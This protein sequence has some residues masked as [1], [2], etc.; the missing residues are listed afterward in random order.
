M[1]GA[2]LYPF[3]LPVTLPICKSQYDPCQIGSL[4][5]C[6]G[7]YAHVSVLTRSDFAMLKF[8]L[9]LLPRARR[10]TL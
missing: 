7:G 1:E 3:Q 5:S 9:S 6:L 4:Q 2:H 8:R 10:F